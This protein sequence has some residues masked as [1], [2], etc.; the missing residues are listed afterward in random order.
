[1][2][3]AASQCRLLFIT[4]RQNDV[5]AKMQRISMDRLS[6][7]RDED[8]IETKYNRMLN[9]TKLQLADGINLS[10]DAMMDASAYLTGKPNIITDNRSGATQGRVVLSSNLATVLR[11]KLGADTGTGS[12]FV[13]KIGSA[14]ALQE[15]LEPTMSAAAASANTQTVTG[16]A[17]DWNS[18]LEAFTATYGSYPSTKKQMTFQ[19]LLQDSALA[20][21]CQNN[22]LSH[23]EGGGGANWYSSKDQVKSA[24]QSYAEKHIESL[25]QWALG[26]DGTQLAGVKAALQPYIDSLKTAAA[27]Q[28][29]Y[30]AGESD[31]NES[32]AKG[33][34]S[35]KATENL[36]GYCH[37][38]QWG[39]GWADGNEAKDWYTVNLSELARRITAKFTEIYAGQ[40]ATSNGAAASTS[41]SGI[42][43]LANDST[44]LVFEYNEKGYSKPVWESKL[45]EEHTN[46]NYENFDWNKALAAAKKTSNTSTGGSESSVKP[47]YQAL[48]NALSSKGWVIDN[49]TSDL[50]SKLENGTYYLNGT[51]LSNNTQLYEEVVDTD[52]QKQAE[53]WYKAET[54][55]IK[56]KED[57]MDMENTKLQTE[58]QAL[59]TDIASVQQIL[60]SNIQ[61]SF[62]YCQ[63]A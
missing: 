9:G 49:D 15:L 8:D 58:Y 7:A 27:A 51:T 22:W 56:R 29:N 36:V 5:S 38:N 23:N 34:A 46:A 57:A 10:Y 14:S 31:S 4:Q 43:S 40:S 60:N 37:E 16:E 50:Q 25:A 54:K 26:M 32:D 20:E 3:L 28:N 13:S 18:K 17:A 44:D 53:A 55:K 63:S 41:L 48:Y 19:K 6:L 30:P 62:Q 21:S 47:Y 42:T 39:N 24:I 12:T 11:P 52:M 61:K 59:A 45:K 33:N 35:G 1:M 2:G